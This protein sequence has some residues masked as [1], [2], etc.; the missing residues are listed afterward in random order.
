MSRYE[1][2]NRKHDRRHRR[3]GHDGSRRNR[4]DALIGGDTSTATDTSQ[5]PI[6]SGGTGAYRDQSE[7]WER[8][9]DGYHSSEDFH[10][11]NHDGGIYG[12]VTTY[13]DEGEYYGGSGYSGNHD[14]YEDDHYRHSLIAAAAPQPF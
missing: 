1:R 14:G 8:Q 13:H 10:P 7:S 11:E 4:R 6:V 3:D 12:A 5:D 9:H 2:R